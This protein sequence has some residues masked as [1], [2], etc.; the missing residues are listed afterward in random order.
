MN[1]HKHQIVIDPSYLLS[2]PA[3][4][5]GRFKTIYGSH[6]KKFGYVK[7]ELLIN[8]AITENI[9]KKYANKLRSQGSTTNDREHQSLRID[10]DEVCKIMGKDTIDLFSKI[11]SEGLSRSAIFSLA[12]MTYL[13]SPKKYLKYTN[14]QW[15]HDNK[16]NQVKCMILLSRTG[17]KDQVTSYIPFSHRRLCLGYDKNSRFT[18]EDIIDLLAKHNS[19]NL[20]GEK[21]SFY[22]FHTNGAHRGNCIA[23]SPERYALT[24]NFT[25]RFSRTV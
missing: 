19:V 15:H 8:S 3:P 9:L 18:D 6:L 16:G 13:D 14:Q 1:R 17:S 4:W 22:F 2:L 21:G 23:D 20:Y 11:A 24:L 10:I 5:S 25:T 7:P 12:T